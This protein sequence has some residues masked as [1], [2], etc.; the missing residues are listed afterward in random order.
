MIVD[1]ACGVNS[2]WSNE[3]E[4]LE[5]ESMFEGEASGEKPCDL[6]A[7]VYVNYNAN[8][9]LGGDAARKWHARCGDNVPGDNINYGSQHGGN[10]GPI[11]NECPFS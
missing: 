8:N 9:W 3:G 5:K 10:D 4:A 1:S 7:K 2:H 6:V 11:C